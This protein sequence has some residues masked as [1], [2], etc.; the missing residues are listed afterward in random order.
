MSFKRSLFKNILTLGGYNYT[1]QIAVFL[2]SIVLSRLLMPDEY[3]FVALITVFTG[4]VSV[5]A[6]AGLSFAIIRS[7]YGLTYHKGVNNLAFYIGTIL[8]SITMLLAFPIA[9]FYDDPKLVLPTMVMS[10]I[11]IF[12]SFNIVPS[13]ILMKRLDFNYIGMVRLISNIVS[14]LLMILFAFLG[15]SYWAL[16]LPNIMMHIVQY[17]FYSRKVKLG[18]RFYRLSYTKAAYRKTKSLITNLSSFNTINYWSRN[19]DNLIIGKVYSNFDLGIY[20]RAYKMLQL[21]HNLISGL[22]GTVL[23]PSLKKLKSDGGDVNKEYS[24]ILGIISIISFP[25]SAILILIP[26]LFVR[27][28]WGPDWMMVAGLLP[29]FGLLILFQSLITTTGHMFILME[30]EKIF[31]RIGIV[32]AVIMVASIVVGAFYSVKM[33]AISY[34]VGYM[35]INVPLYLYYGFSKTFGYNFRHIFR[36]WAPKL[37]FGILVLV[38]ELIDFHYATFG[39]MALY[40]AHLVYLQG[41]DLKKLKEMVF[42]KLGINYR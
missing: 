10:T 1:S 9:Y 40:A 39:L 36:F 12:G 34:T 4:F 13:A 19:A 42:V 16:I 31:M 2:S 21:S 28:L 18:F 35:L 37:A 11:F 33:I 14:I 17:I 20:N 24:N 41:N 7:D 6:D 3:G 30:K 15:F 27:I 5:F 32:S 22:F 25:I 38:S 8:F 26:D 23:Y 29:F